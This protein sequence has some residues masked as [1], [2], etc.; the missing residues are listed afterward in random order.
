M[1]NINLPQELELGIQKFVVDKNTDCAKMRSALKLITVTPINSISA[2]S[3]DHMANKVLEIS[4]GDQYWGSVVLDLMKSAV[5][6]LMKLDLRT[7]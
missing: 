3:N 4:I 5:Y 7:L 1:L 2:S 6:Y